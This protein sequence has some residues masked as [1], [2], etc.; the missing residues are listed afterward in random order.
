MRQSVL[1][2]YMMPVPGH[3]SACICITVL[4]FICSDERDVFISKLSNDAFS[5]LDE[6][7]IC[8][9]GNHHI[10]FLFTCCHAPKHSHH[11]A[12]QPSVASPGHAPP[13]MDMWTHNTLSMLLKDP[14][15]RGPAGFGSVQGIQSS[16]Q[17]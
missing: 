8:H 17:N 4:I 2:Q 11:P 3:L 6:I 13:I 1:L 7:W 10:W 5:W 15:L 12:F 9:H 16:P 14:G